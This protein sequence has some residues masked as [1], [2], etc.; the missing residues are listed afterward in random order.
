MTAPRPATTA[1]PGRMCDQAR[2]SRMS[3]RSASITYVTGLNV[4]ATS[5]GRV[6]RSRGTKFGVRNS[7][8]KKT[9]PPEFVAAA[10]RVFSAMS[11]MKPV[12]TTDHIAVRPISSTKPSGPLAREI[13]NGR[14]SSRSAVAMAVPFT[15]SATSRP[16]TMA[17]RETGAARSLSK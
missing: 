7:S 4:A 8:G 12:K 14:A 16:S 15:A 13:P 3:E 9:S 2:S 10:L 1:K 17:V 5:I 6:S 11:C